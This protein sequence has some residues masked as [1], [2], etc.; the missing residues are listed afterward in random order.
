MGWAFWRIKSMRWYYCKFYFYN[1]RLGFSYLK[2]KMMMYKNYFVFGQTILDKVAILAGV[3]TNI[4]VDHQGGWVLDKIVE[5]GKGGLV[6]SAHIG[7]WE[8]AGQRMNRLN[9]K[10]NILMYE[11]EKENLKKYMD[12]VQKAGGTDRRLDQYVARLGSELLDPSAIEYRARGVVE[13]MA[14]ALQGSLLVRYGNPAVADAFCAS[15]LG[16]HYSGMTFGAMPRGLDCA[17]II[18][19]ATPRL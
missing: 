16:E 6:M 10:F 15:R 7:N 11:N 13:K 1:K 5:E 14:L 19:R 2:S 8:M 9:T 4:S 17:V 18:E 12:E 3:K